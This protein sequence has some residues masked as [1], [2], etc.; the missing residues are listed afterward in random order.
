M[1]NQETVSALYS[2]QFRG[3]VSIG[4]EV[5]NCLADAKTYKLRY[6]K[7]NNGGQSEVEA[8]HSLHTQGRT[9]YDISTII[10]DMRAS[11]GF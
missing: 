7:P 2:A 5:D 9:P 3:N 8:A 6:C 11:G 4:E 10:R 1:A